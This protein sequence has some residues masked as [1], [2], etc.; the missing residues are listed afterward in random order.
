MPSMADGETWP[1]CDLAALDL[2]RNHRMISQRSYSEAC[3]A[4]QNTLLYV[5]MWRLN[6]SLG[7]MES[8]I[9]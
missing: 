5:P 7:D 4:L 2:M 1:G 6:I 8:Y 9:I 3:I